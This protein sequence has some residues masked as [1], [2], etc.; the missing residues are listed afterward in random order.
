MLVNGKASYGNPDEDAED[1][2]RHA[3]C[4]AGG[5]DDGDG[6]FYGCGWFILTNDSQTVSQA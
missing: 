3:L 6:K 5:L 4:I 1:D 2:T